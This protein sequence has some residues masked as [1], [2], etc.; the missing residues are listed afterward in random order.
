MR[1]AGYS[2]I[3]SVTGKTSAAERA[4]VLVGIRARPDAARLLDFVVATSAF[5]LGIDYAHIRSVVHACLPETVDRWY[6]ELGRG[7]RDGDVCAGFLLT[8]PEDYDE[9]ASLAPRV[10]TPE[11]AEKRWDDLWDHRSAVGGG[12]RWT[13]RERAGRLDGGDYNRRWNAQVIQGLIELGELR[14]EQ[15]DVEDLREVLNKD[16]VEVSDGPR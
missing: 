5:G 8:A 10:L 6:Q 1:T 12:A 13:S 3:A 2:R 4:A 14:R 15:F 16:E 7:G 11:T 9:A